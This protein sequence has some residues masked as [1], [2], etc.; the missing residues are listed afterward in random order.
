MLHRRGFFSACYSSN[1]KR[2]YACGGNDG[3]TD[4]SACET[5]AIGS[6]K[7]E[8]LPSLTHAR[9]GSACEFN[10]FNSSILVA[11]GSNK[12]IGTMAI[13]E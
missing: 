4:L 6:Q 10:E 9:N 5:L 3:D 12:Q 7:W 1:F 8:A 13:I 2:I 11:G